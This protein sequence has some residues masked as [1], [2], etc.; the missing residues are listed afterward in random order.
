MPYLSKEYEEFLIEFK[1]RRHSLYEKICN[2]TE[3]ILPIPP[4]RDIEK[5]FLEA[6]SF[7]HLDITPKGALSL[8]FLATILIPII[9]ILAGFIFNLLSGPYI[10]LLV[11]LTI[12]IFYYLYSL[13]YAI[14][15]SF[16]IKASSEMVLA[17]I[18]MSVAMK[19][20]PNL[21]YAVKFAASNLTGPLAKDLKKILWDVY[22]GRYVT[23][24]DALDEFIRKWKRENEEF[25]EALYLMKTAFFESSLQRDKVLSEAVSIVLSGT[26]E[27]METYSQE[28]KTPVTVLNAIGILLPIVG[29]VFFPLVS[30][31]IP[32]A[33]SPLYLVVGYDIILPITVYWLMRTSLQKRPATFHQPEISKHPKFVRSKSEPIIFFL[34]VA[35]SAVLIGF[36]YNQINL[37]KGQLF[38]LELLIY[39][40]LIIWS[41]TFGVV[42]YTLLT[43]INKLKLREEV[44]GIESELGEV[45]FQIGTQLSRGM[46][47]EAALRNSLPKIKELKISKMVEKILY[48]IESLGM[49]FSSAVFDENSGAINYFPSKLISAVMKAV[50]EISKGGMASL[51]DAMISIANFLRNMHIVEEDLKEKLS[52]IVGTM[53]IQAILLAPLSTGI[54]VSVY[55]I[56]MQIIVSLS[57]FISEFQSK[58][59]SYGTSGDV[60]TGIIN[61]NQVVGVHVTQL[62]VGIYMVE[63]VSMMAL[64]TSIIK[65]GEDKLL[66]KY[67]IGKTL[68]LGTIIY[69]VVSLFIYTGLTAF[70]PIAELFR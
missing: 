52:D 20:I 51:S 29:L 48:N 66:R 10:V 45:L 24:A 59:A 13:P 49:T 12:S 16:K 7:S 50:V 68:L 44:A 15:T 37:F 22:I 30:I 26:K 21:E 34:A 70:V 42:F 46:P 60:L 38:S 3:K 11:V 40:M 67:T 56:M 57:G 9:L 2:V 65:H 41:I 62:I 25:T 35:I 5:K 69:S 53:D 28:L 64:F 31:F 43:T 36:S 39:S 54:V 19:V 1:F 27:R 4:T 63:V 17:I 18:Y 23:I 32:E 47:V 6:I 61:I 33:I 55:A 8:T 14:A 58:L